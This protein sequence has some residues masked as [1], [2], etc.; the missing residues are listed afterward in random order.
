MTGKTVSSKI[1]PLAN[2]IQLKMLIEEISGRT[3]GLPGLGCFYGP[4]GF[5]KSFSAIYMANAR[6]VCHVQALPFGGTKKLLDMIVTELGLR[7]KRTTSDMFDQVAEA[8]ARTG[9]TLIIDEAD[10]ILSDRQIEAIRFLHEMTGAPVILMGE[11]MLP[12]KLRRWERVNSRIMRWVAAQ[13]AT[14][15]DVSHLAAVYADGVRLDDAI[16]AAILRAA[17][18]SIRHVSTNLAI[19]AEFARSRGV[20]QVSLGDWGD[21]PFNTSRP[22]EARSLIVRGE[23]LRRE[24]I[25]KGAAA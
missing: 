23:P 11:E 21:R 25:R 4:A 22:P 9:K 5:G 2:V 15:N 19:V 7:P 10:Q 14:M 16:K 13:P 17:E 24:A 3:F 8:L 12:Q 6:D 18:G 20:A 1:A